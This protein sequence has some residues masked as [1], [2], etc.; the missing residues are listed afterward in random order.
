MLF[1]ILRIAAAIL[2]FIIIWI[3]VPWVI[4]FFGGPVPP[5][6]L[7][8]AIAGFCAI[9]WFAADMRY[10]WIETRFGPRPVA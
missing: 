4:Q 10:G 2:L 7:M 6:L 9:V 1:W 5:D 3:G 8:K